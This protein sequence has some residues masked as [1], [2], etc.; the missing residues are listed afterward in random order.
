MANW[1]SG[2]WFVPANL[3]E[4]GR[5]LP[6]QQGAWRWIVAS[7]T[8]H[9]LPLA[10]RRSRTMTVRHDLKVPRESFA[11]SSLPKHEILRRVSLNHHVSWRIICSQ[12]AAYQG[13]LLESG[14]LGNREAMASL[15]KDPPEH[16]ANCGCSQ[17]APSPNDRVNQ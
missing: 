14:R 15:G 2:V 9:A 6:R 1:S 10:E 7:W 12:L 16:L 8:T 13:V 4:S 11:E 3:C 5:H 17:Y